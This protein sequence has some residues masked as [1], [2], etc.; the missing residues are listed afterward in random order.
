VTDPLSNR[1]TPFS[2][3]PPGMDADGPIP[4][5]LLDDAPVAVVLLDEDG[6]VL[7]RNPAARQLLSPFHRGPVGKDFFRELVPQLE[8]EGVG[9]RYRVGM[10]EGRVALSANIEIRTDGAPQRLR[11]EI[12]STSAPRQRLG[13]VVLEDHSALAREEERRERA[14]RLAAVGEIAR[15]VAHEVNNPLASI[16]SFAQLILQDTSNESH[17]EALEIV[18]KECSR[19]SRTIDDLLDFAHGQEIEDRE[20]LALSALVEKLIGLKRYGLETSGIEIQ[21]ELDPDLSPVTGNAGALQRAVLHLILNAERAL[22]ARRT[23]RILVVQTRES[24]DGVTITIADNGQGIAREELRVLLDPARSR[25]EADARIGLAIVSSTAR[26][27]GGSFWVESTQGRGTAYFLRL[28]HIGEV[29]EPGAAGDA[30]SGGEPEPSA[31]HAPRAARRGRRVLVADDEA[32]LRL[33]LALCLGREGH[34]VVQASNARDALRIAQEGA[35]DVALVDARMPGD[36]FALVE[37]LETL[38]ALR[39]RVALMSGDVH[40]I[41]A[42]QQRFPQRLYLAKPFDMAEVVR[43]VEQLGA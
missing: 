36:G 12:R 41:R 11:L 33:A 28:P 4:W 1:P 23:H 2:T 37:E 25:L 14:E 29:P 34:E 30:G 6:A 22:S 32:S 27:H 43:L 7:H 18:S 16:K 17:R 13:V 24:T 42:T 15:G 19:I 39:G 31:A 9:A 35:I 38:P 40:Y 8:A 20:T 10:A 26:A 3:F 21:M 5:A